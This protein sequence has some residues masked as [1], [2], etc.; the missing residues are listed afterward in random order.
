MAGRSRSP[1]PPLR[2]HGVPAAHLGTL[3]REWRGDWVGPSVEIGARSLLPLVKEHADFEGD[4]WLA[5]EEPYVL[6][7]RSVQ[8]SLDFSLWHGLCPAT[9]TRL[10]FCRGSS[11]NFQ[12]LVFNWPRAPRSRGRV[13]VSRLIGM[14]LFF[15]VARWDPLFR[16]DQ[17]LHVH[18]RDHDHSNCFL[19]NLE[20][21]LASE[22]VALHNRHRRR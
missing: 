7:L 15:R 22:H 2:R 17:R 18:H 20:V 4:V 12:A 13:I 19:N 9:A 6:E 3:L 1:V 10:N 11:N 14:S 16:F 8:F 21:K 5:V